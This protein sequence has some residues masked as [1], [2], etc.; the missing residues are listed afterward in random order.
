MD[1]NKIAGIYKITNNT[2]GKVYIGESEN[3][4]RRWIEHIMALTYGEHKNYKL[5]NDF[6]EYGLKAFDFDIVELFP[7]NEE[8]NNTKLK[9]TLLC[10][11]HAYIKY[12]NSLETGYN[13]EYTLKRIL[14]KEKGLFNSYNPNINKDKDCNLLKGF[15]NDNKDV[16]KIESEVSKSMI[17][18]KVK[19][20]KFPKS[21]LGL[22][23]INQ[24][25]NLE[26]NYND[27]YTILNNER[28]SVSDFLNYIS[29]YGVHITNYAFIKIFNQYDYAKFSS[30][31]NKYVIN[32]DFD[33]YFISTMEI[34]DE[35][36]R[37]IIY[38]TPEGQT[39]I[40]PIII[41]NLQVE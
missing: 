29:S 27:N 7:T 3:I 41:E 33:K 2:N 22:I 25:N 6:K 35:K 14:N 16:L 5:Q 18:K 32:K 34:V 1:I 17:N 37:N 30:Q 11:E 19:E 12:F 40:F 10:R 28:I 36:R 8:F 15:L 13:L 4:P 20:R 21:K 9:L 31:L 26:T 38:I 23:K 24:N 39:M